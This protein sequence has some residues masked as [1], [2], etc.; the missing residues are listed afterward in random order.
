M[1]QTCQT[2]NERMPIST[3][4]NQERIYKRYLELFKI[5]NGRTIDD[6]LTEANNPKRFTKIMRMK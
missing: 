2:K 4:E 6:L 5:R 1:T 3:S